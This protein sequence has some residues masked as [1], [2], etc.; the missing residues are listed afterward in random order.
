MNTVALTLQMKKEVSETVSHSCIV[1]RFAASSL[2][3][4]CLVGAGGRIRNRAVKS[5]NP[6]PSFPTVILDLW[7]PWSLSNQP[8]VQASPSPSLFSLWL[9]IDLNFLVHKMTTTQHLHSELF[10]LFCL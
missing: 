9:C 10:I 6:S 1:A 4:T 7:N 5:Q 3:S 8:Y 2:G